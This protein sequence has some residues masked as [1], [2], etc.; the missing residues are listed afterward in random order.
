MFNLKDQPGD[1]SNVPVRVSLKDQVA[2]DV[3]QNGEIL[4]RDGVDGGV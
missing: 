2:A 4:K 1:S 3:D